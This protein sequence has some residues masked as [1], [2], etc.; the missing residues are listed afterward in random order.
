M[1]DYLKKDQY[2]TDLYDLAT[3][4]KCLYWENAYTSKDFIKIKDEKLNKRSFTELTLYYVKGERYKNRA[5]RIREWQEK[6]VQRQE[7]FDNASDPKNVYC[8]NCSGTTHVTYKTLE[9][10]TDQPLR[11]L[12]FFECD[13]CKKR[14]AIYDNGKEHISKPYLCPKCSSELK[15]TYKDSG[16]VLTTK[17]KCTSCDYS[18]TEV[19]DFEKKQAEWDKKEAEDGRKLTQYRE[20]YCL[21][22]SEGGKYVTQTEEMKQF[23]QSLKEGQEKKADSKYQKAVKAKKLTIAELEKFLSNVLEDE[24]YI[25]LSFDNPEMGKFVIVPFTVQDTGY[26]RKDYDSTRKLQKILKTTLETTNW[27][28]MSEGTSYRMGYVYG[29]LKGYEREEDLAELFGWKKDVQ[30]DKSASGKPFSLEFELDDP[31]KRGYEY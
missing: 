15:T 27:R 20:K 22:E 6:D 13:S 30:Q 25:K 29:R 3:I 17:D 11:V 1:R 21:S 12:F 31:K 5:N 4:E 7:M 10:Y 16:E 9:D 26:K 8:K 2:Y 14:R 18:K 19:D 23:M 28:L 24:K